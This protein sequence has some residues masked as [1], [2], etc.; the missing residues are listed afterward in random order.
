MENT[1]KIY[2]QSGSDDFR[3]RCIL[4]ECSKANLDVVCIQEECRFNCDSIA[5]L[6]YKL[7]GHKQKNNNME[8][9]F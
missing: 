9:E 3:V 7:N 8:L 4:E 6:G 5:H 1:K 2:V